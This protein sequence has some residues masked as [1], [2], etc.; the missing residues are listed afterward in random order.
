VLEVRARGD[1][2]HVVRGL[3]GVLRAQLRVHDE[4]RD[5]RGER[6]AP[7]ERLA[8]RARDPL[9]LERDRGVQ[10]AAGRGV[11]V[12]VQPEEGDDALKIG[13]W[14]LMLLVSPCCVGNLKII[15]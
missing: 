13:G 8:Q 6:G 14:R 3:L 12:L 5:E 10:P 2:A 4:L 9:A 15:L 7:V 1:D 11:P